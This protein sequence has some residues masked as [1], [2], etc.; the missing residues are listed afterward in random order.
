MRFLGIDTPE[1]SFAP[2][3]DRNNFIPTN[4]TYWLE[5]FTDPF[6][7][8]PNFRSQLGDELVAYILAK[9]GDNTAGNHYRYSVKARDALRAEIE[10]DM[11]R[12]GQNNETF[13]FFAR[14]SEEVIDRYGRLLAY[15]NCDIPQESG[16]RPL[17]YNER[18]LK[19][20]LA[21]PYFIW[22][23]M[24]PFNDVNTIPTPQEL[25]TSLNIG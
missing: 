11:M 14:F 16:R 17:F 2:K 10:G 19:Q 9:I 6:K 18:L 12:L 25:Q 3:H 4:D 21:A 24:N 1:I 13:K 5:Y 15:L 7:D 20:G 8:A 23:N 22:P